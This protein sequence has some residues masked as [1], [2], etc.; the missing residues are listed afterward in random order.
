M[1]VSVVFLFSGLG[2][3]ELD[4]KRVLTMGFGYDL[5]RKKC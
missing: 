4:V 1:V 2:G 5:R 3:G